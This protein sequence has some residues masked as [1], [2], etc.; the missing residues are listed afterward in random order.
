MWHIHQTKHIPSQCNFMHDLTSSH[1]DK[2]CKESYVL[3]LCHT[4][5]IALHASL[6]SIS[7]LC[8]WYHPGISRHIAES[9]LVSKDVQ[10]GTYLLRDCVSEVDIVTLSVRYFNLLLH[11]WEKLQYLPTRCQ[12]SVKHYKIPW[13]GKQF[14]FGLGK[15]PNLEAF[16]NHFSHQPVISGMSGTSSWFPIHTASTCVTSSTHVTHT[17]QPTPTHTYPHTQVS[18]FS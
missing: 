7:S 1:I 13:D 6:N 18:W 11:Y 10:D 12:D 4:I 8:R 9:L 14:L 3:P 2:T 17:C 15:F 5:T 16:T